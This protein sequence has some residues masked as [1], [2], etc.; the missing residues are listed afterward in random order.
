MCIKIII[1]FSKLKRE[2]KYVI[3]S[4]LPKN[5]T[6]YV[7]L[8]LIALVVYFYISELH[9]A[10]FNDNALVNKSY[11]LNIYT[12]VHKRIYSKLSQK[13]TRKV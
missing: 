11:F 2:W 3:L 4:A 6:L 10:L 8:L 9:R 13:S 12:N 1:L 5:N 7:C